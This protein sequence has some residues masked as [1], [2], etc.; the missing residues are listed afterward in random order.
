[1]REFGNGVSAQRNHVDQWV[2]LPMVV[3]SADQGVGVDAD[4][5]SAVR[6]PLS[7]DPIRFVPV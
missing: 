3:S 2:P 4:K 7:A 5:S 1:V 6:H